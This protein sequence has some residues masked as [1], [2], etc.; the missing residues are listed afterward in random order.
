MRTEEQ[1]VLAFNV[2]VPA[3]TAPISPAFTVPAFTVPAFIVPAFTVPAFT[4]PGSCGRRDSLAC[5]VPP[6]TSG[7]TM[8]RWVCV[9]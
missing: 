9:G 1:Q 5:S 8:R 6:N 3:F 7:S 2:T 4:V